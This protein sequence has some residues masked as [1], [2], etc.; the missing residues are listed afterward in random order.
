M[1]NVVALLLACK[2]RLVRMLEELERWELRQ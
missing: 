2:P 1:R